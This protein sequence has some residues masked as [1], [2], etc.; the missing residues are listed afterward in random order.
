MFLSSGDNNFNGAT[1]I[2]K[3]S[4]FTGN[5]AGYENGGVMSLGLYSKVTIAGDG[6]VFADNL[7]DGNGGVLS[8]LSDTKVIIE[9]GKYSKNLGKRVSFSYSKAFVLLNFRLNK[10]VLKL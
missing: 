1:A 10:A 7:C 6:N 2:I 3:S 4:T 9:G 5:T 8:A